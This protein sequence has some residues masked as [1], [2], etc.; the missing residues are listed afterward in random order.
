MSHSPIQY[1]C[2]YQLKVLLALLSVQFLVCLSQAQA[3]PQKFS[4]LEISCPSETESKDIYKNGILNKKW[5]EPPTNPPV[6]RPNPIVQENKTE[7]RRNIQLMNIHP[8]PR[9]NPIHITHVLA[10]T[11]DKHIIN[12]TCSHNSIT[13]DKSSAYLFT[14]TTK[15]LLLNNKTSADW[16]LVNVTLYS[17]I[18]NEAVSFYY[19]KLCGVDYETRFDW[20][21]ILLLVIS[22]LLVAIG[23]RTLTTV[24]ENEELSIVHVFI[25]V[26]VFTGCYILLYYWAE[27][28][29]FTA[30]I[31]FSIVSLLATAFVFNTLLKHFIGVG[32]CLIIRRK[33]IC[34]WKVRFTD[35]ASLLLAGAIIALWYMKKKLDYCRCASDYPSIGINEIRKDSLYESRSRFTFI[36]YCLACDLV[37]CCG[38]APTSGW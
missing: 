13:L 17:N 34:F 3:P 6:C 37:V 18:T 9:E 32:D 7:S 31:V 5:I 25:Y 28:I 26:A 24:I 1:K 11:N 12:V 15:C 30:R 38:T 2:S 8:Y 36:R 27:E 19:Q 16:G 23:A 21:Y 35:V 20:G 4:K 33:F 14:I 10:T 22:T 29:E